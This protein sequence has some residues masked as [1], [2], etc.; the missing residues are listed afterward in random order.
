MIHQTHS[1]MAN[2]W[3]PILKDLMNNPNFLQLE[4]LG[5]QEVSIQ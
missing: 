1:L 2:F 5:L 4:S 3:I